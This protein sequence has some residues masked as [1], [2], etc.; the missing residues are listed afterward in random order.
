MTFPELSGA[1]F[2]AGNSGWVL[3]GGLESASAGRA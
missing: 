3:R 1:D 2:V